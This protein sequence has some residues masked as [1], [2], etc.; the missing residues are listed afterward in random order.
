MMFSI[1][2]HMVWHPWGSLV[3]YTSLKRWR[4]MCS[5]T[6]FPYPLSLDLT[7]PGGLNL[8]MYAAKVMGKY[9][10]CIGYYTMCHYFPS[11]TMH[12]LEKYSPGGFIYFSVIKLLFIMSLYCDCVMCDNV[13][14]SE[15]LTNGNGGK[16]GKPEVKNF[17]WKGAKI[18][19]EEL[20]IP[21]RRILSNYCLLENNE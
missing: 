9:T 1:W 20:G 21:F 16:W 8:P 15:M 19:V 11:L 14:P 2:D 3:S 10:T 6:A 12:T 4:M 5:W 17:V 18:K 7:S 13:L